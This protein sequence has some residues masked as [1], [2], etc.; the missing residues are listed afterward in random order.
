MVSLPAT[1]FILDLNQITQFLF[2]L[3]NG[4]RKKCPF[5]SENERMKYQNNSMKEH[6]AVLENFYL[7][8]LEMLVSMILTYEMVKLF[9]EPQTLNWHSSS[10][11]QII[12][13][14]LF[15]PIS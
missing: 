12:F 2:P 14:L 11:D 9:V 13:Q 10:T 3:L 5:F 1:I 8:F 15:I 4:R 7:K 6:A